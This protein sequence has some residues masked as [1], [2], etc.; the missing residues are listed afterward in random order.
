MVINMR[1]VILIGGVLAAGKST[2]ANILKEK[3]NLTVV[4]K[5]RLK[6]IL[7]DNIYV[8]N[9]EENKKLSVICFD[10]IKY[11]LDCNK[12]NIVFE[13]NFKE[14][15]LIELKRICEDLNY[16]VMSLIFDADNEVLH[17]RFNKRINENRHYVH[18]SQDFTDINDFI[19]VI[20]QLRNAPY[21]GEIVK[22][23]CNDFSY[24][25]K[26]SINLQAE[27]AATA[28]SAVAVVTWRIAFVRQSPAT[29]IPASA[30]SGT[31]S[32]PEMI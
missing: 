9:R 19:P 18:K 23:D 7:G 29:K 5:D 17:K 14:Y 27:S 30:P 22:V 12:T 16:D 10:L 4:T 26:P 20:D 8:E 32:S 1:K 25:A 15:E 24:Q 21:F 11:L 2:Y 31:Q 6:E 13:S 28:P 3:Y